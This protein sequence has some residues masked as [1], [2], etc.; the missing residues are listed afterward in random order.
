MQTKRA[1][2]DIVSTVLIIMIAV[3]A[4]GLIGGLVVPM[5]RNSLQGGTTCFNALTDISIVTDEGYTC[6][7]GTNLSIQIGKQSDNTVVI[8]DLKFVVE[9][10]TGN[11]ISYL[12]SVN[13]TPKTFP[14]NGERKVYTV[15]NV[16]VDSTTLSLIPIVKLGNTNKE[17]DSAQ[18]IQIPKC[19]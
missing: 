12:A 14:G 5:V 4:I 17:C 1:I 3:A 9:D 2:S 10:N 16:N 11:S 18:K 8:S 19:I 15:S 13:A 6:L 7:N